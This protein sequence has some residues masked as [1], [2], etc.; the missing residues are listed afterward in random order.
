MAWK[1]LSSEEK[2]RSPWISVTEDQ[3]ETELGNLLTWSV[4]HKNDCAMVIP[5]DDARFGLVGLYRYSVNEFSW[6]FPAGSVA[7]L[8]M[9]ETAKRELKE[10]TGLTAALYESL[11]RFYLA[12]GSL[13]QAMDLYLATGLTAGET[14]HDPGEE[15]MQFK[16][17]TYQE[18]CQLIADGELKDGPTITAFGFLHANGWVKKQGL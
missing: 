17:V 12:N 15:G 7:G 10:E 9:E 14:E 16:W 5:W 4:V 3:V 13:T 8:T 1:Q 11:G 6:E 2:Y 18:L